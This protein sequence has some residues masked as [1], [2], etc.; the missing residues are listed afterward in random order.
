VKKIA[1]L[2]ALALAV[3][4]APTASA[5]QRSVDLTFDKSAVAEGVWEGTVAGDIEGDLRTELKRRRV[6]GPIW[7]V[8]FDWIVTGAG[9]RS[10]VARLRGTLDTRTGEVAMRGRVI[11]GYLRGARVREEGRLVDPATSRFVG[12]IRIKKQSRRDD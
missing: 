7:H 5:S 9:E 3:T 2:L 4:A 1:V 8:T 6:S 10:F 12:S 11:R